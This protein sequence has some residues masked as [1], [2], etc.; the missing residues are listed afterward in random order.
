AMFSYVINLRLQMMYPAADK[1]LIS[2]KLG[3]TGTSGA[4]A[5]TEPF[6]VTPLSGKTRKKVLMLSQLYLQLTSTGSSPLGKN[7]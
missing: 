4:N 1:A 5:T 2:L 7:I 6:Q 3:F